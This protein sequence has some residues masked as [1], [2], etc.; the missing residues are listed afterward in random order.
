MALF[1]A[2]YIETKL[3]QDVK[4]LRLLKGWTREILGN[5]SGVSIK[6]IQRLESGKGVSIQ[7]MVKIL[8][9]LGRTDW[10]LNLSPA[11]SINP[12]DPV[13]NRRRGK[14]KKNNK[15]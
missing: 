4:K 11:I 9:V 15:L 7:S 3:G 2:S 13:S 8:I 12:L 1:T 5:M 14:R 10:L 6:S